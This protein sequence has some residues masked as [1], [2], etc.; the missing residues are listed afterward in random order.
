MDYLGEWHTHLKCSPSP[1]TIG[2]ND[3][4]QILNMRQAPKVLMI[5]GTQ[6]QLWIWPGIAPGLHPI[7][8]LRAH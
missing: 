6:N 3:W 5:S 1:S 4:E 7:P 8:E 2:T